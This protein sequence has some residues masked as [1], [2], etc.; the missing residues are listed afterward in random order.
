MCGSVRKGVRKAATQKKKAAEKKASATRFREAK[1]AAQRHRKAVTEIMAVPVRVTK[2][3]AQRVAG[4][5]FGVFTPEPAP[6]AR[7]T[8]KSGKTRGKR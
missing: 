8:T 3:S 1:G 7:R 5:L 6:A 4:Y 2:E